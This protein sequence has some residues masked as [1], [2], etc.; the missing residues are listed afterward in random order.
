M[1]LAWLSRARALEPMPRLRHGS[2]GPFLP[3][4]GQES[5]PPVADDGDVG[6]GAVTKE[7]A[8]QT[9]ST[10]AGD[11]RKDEIEREMTR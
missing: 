8:P 3:K 2:Y 9:S 11:N 5:G 4:E 6:S 1:L 10:G 7:M